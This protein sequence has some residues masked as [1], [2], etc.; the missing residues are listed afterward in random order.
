MSEIKTVIMQLAKLLPDLYL[1]LRPGQPVFLQAG[2]SQE[3]FLDLIVEE[4]G[5]SSAG[6]IMVHLVDWLRRT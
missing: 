1:G 2:K 6:E 3:D 4:V 5:R